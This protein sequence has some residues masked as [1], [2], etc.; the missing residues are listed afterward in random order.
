MAKGLYTILHP[1]KYLG[2]PRKCRFLSSWE[3]RFFQYADNNPAVVK[4]GS[5]QFKVPYFHPIKKKVCT[6][7]PD[8]WIQ[9]KLPD[10]TIRTEVIEIKPKKQSVISKNMSNY[11]KV[12]LVI[13]HAKWLACKAICDRGGIGFRICTED[14]IFSGKK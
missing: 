7:I 5:E 3:L 2:D 6:Y 4:W 13:N 1:E 12:S 10:G 11:D 14:D 8:I 9:I